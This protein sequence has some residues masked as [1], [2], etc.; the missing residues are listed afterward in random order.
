M[1]DFA[2]LNKSAQQQAALQQQIQGALAANPA[3]ID[4][5]TKK[6]MTREQVERKILDAL[7]QEILLR[8]QIERLS[9][10]SGARAQLQ[11]Y[12]AN[13]DKSTGQTTLTYK[14]K[15][16]GFIPNF[17]N[18]QEYVGALAEGQSYL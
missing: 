18:M 7:K 13:I 10:G 1:A 3:L 15:S 12:G 6:E 11:G 16:R 17:S 14:N 8:E 5:I 2:N 9:A 4:S